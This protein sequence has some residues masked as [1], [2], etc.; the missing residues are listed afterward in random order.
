MLTNIHFPIDTIGIYT[1][2]F[3]ASRLTK[4]FVSTSERIRS[5]MGNWTYSE[6]VNGNESATH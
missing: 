6:L 4:K 1:K 3:T 5:E 2:L